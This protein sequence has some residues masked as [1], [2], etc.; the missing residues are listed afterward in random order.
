MVA[1]CDIITKSRGCGKPYICK[2]RVGYR[3]ERTSIPYSK[4]QKI[5]LLVLYDFLCRKTDEEHT[6]S[7]EKIINE[8]SKLNIALS[9]KTMSAERL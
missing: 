7:I 1:F 2:C 6:L 3:L 5:K 8:L 4:E 9:R